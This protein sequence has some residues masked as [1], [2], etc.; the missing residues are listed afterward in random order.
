MPVSVDDLTSRMAICSTADAQLPSP[1]SE[2]DQA[3]RELTRGLSQDILHE[4]KEPKPGQI[5]VRMR[6]IIPGAP[7]HGLPFKAYHYAGHDEAVEP[8]ENHV[9]EGCTHTTQHK[10]ELGSDGKPTAVR[11]NTVAWKPFNTKEDLYASFIFSYMDRTKLV[12]LGFCDENGKPTVAEKSRSS[13]PLMVLTPSKL[14]KRPDNDDGDE[15]RAKRMDSRIGSLPLT[16]GKTATRTAATHPND[17]SADLIA[18]LSR[19]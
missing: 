12:K 6:R 10:S 5:E 18:C 15:L 1:S 13:Q 3:L 11:M 19:R 17:D 16:Q 2:E 4:N 14:R 9:K 7:I 8:S